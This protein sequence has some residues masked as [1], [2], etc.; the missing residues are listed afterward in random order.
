MFKNL[1]SKITWRKKQVETVPEKKRDFVGGIKTTAAQ[2]IEIKKAL[3][4]KIVGMD[5][6][7]VTIVDGAAEIKYLITRVQDDGSADLSGGTVK[8]SGIHDLQKFVDVVAMAID[9]PA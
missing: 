1:L 3:E 8:C 5:C 6:D 9:K 2:C 4:S 7:D